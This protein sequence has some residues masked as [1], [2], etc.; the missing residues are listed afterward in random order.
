M[1]D[2]TPLWL[3]GDQLGPHFHRTQAHKGRHVLL[4]IYRNALRRKRYR[5]Q[6]LHLVL[7]AIRHL[8][9][10]LGERATLVKAATYREA[11]R[12]TGRGP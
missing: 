1:P 5:R 12:P 10:D 2:E 7:S 3:F 11:L 6:K 8:A 4:V 9:C